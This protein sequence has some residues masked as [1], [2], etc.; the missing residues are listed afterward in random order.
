M[1]LG[2]QEFQ[3]QVFERF[4]SVDKH[5]GEIRDNQEDHESRLVAIE[6]DN[7]GR[8]QQVE[9]NTEGLRSLTDEIRTVKAMV[10]GL[11]T[12]ADITAEF[13]KAIDSRNLFYLRW[14]TGRKVFGGVFIA[15]VT[16][17]GTK[18]LESWGFPI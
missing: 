5:I 3:E 1:S 15:A 18:L 13:N 10:S 6:S 14:I 8:D 7:T 9:R 11:P 16:Y 12:K 2:Q 4:D 17:V